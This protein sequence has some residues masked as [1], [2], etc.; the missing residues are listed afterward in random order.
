MRITFQ[1]EEHSVTREGDGQVL[2]DALSLIEDA[3]LGFGFRFTGELEIVDNR[4]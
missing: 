1:D 2:C 4:E 3:L